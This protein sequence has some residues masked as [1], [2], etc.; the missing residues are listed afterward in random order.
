MQPYPHAYQ[1]KYFCIYLKNQQLAIYNSQEP[2]KRSIILNMQAA[3][4]KPLGDAWR[5]K[6]VTSTKTDEFVSVQLC[7]TNVQNPT[8]PNYL[9]AWQILNLDKIFNMSDSD[10]CLIFSCDTTYKHFCLDQSFP[11]KG[12]YNFSPILGNK[13]FDILLKKVS[14]FDS[15]KGLKG[16]AIYDENDQIKELYIAIKD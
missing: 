6:L 1:A 8:N 3:I 10:Q 15:S 12:K 13:K 7:K 14:L 5:V 11:D 2:I 4:K 16:S 9:S